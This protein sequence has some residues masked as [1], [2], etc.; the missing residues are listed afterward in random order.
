MELSAC[1]PFYRKKNVAGFIDREACVRSS[2]AEAV[3]REMNIR[4]SMLP[5]KFRLLYHANINPDSMM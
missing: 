5:H 2:V 3:G 1:F 4:C